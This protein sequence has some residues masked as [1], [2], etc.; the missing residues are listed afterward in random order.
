LKNNTEILDGVRIFLDCENSGGGKYFRW[1]YDE[2]W[3]FSVPNPKKYDYIDQN[4]IPVVDQIK[5]VCYEHNGSSEILIHSTEASQADRIEKEPILFVASNT[6]DR[7]LIQYCI[8]IKQL[9][10]SSAEFHFWDQMKKINETGGN[11]FDKQPF[12]VIGNIHNINDAS[13]T[14]LGYFQVSAVEEKRLYIFH[15]QIKN[16]GLPEY[17][18]DCER[19][20]V[21]PDDYAV[22]QDTSQN[23]TFDKIYE[24]YIDIGYIFTRP[25]VDF[26]GNLSKL[27]FTR[28]VC[29]ICTLRGN[30]SAPYFWIDIE[31]NQKKR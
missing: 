4:N 18:Y 20:E 17:Y 11:I 16:M 1:T 14:V 26:R 9:S 27:A 23:M 29:A 21:G 2:W 24:S 3:K 25:M 22:S 12:S 10:L 28:P 7:F 31:S 5:Q 30:L 19:V 6:T 15:E 13:E 8:D